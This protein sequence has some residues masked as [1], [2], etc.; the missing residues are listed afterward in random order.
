[1]IYPCRDCPRQG[2]GAYHSECELYQEAL[3]QKEAEKKARN[4]D[5]VINEYEVI[6]GMDFSRRSTN[7]ARMKRYKNER[8]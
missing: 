7:V 8:L 5:Y 2:C 6:R 1:M 4:K 3:R